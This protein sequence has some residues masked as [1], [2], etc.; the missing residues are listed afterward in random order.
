MDDH[1]F[2]FTY[3]GRESEEVRKIREKYLP[4]R[5]DNLEKLRRLDKSA[6]EK[7]T[8]WS[9]V[10]G[11][12]GTLILGGGMSMCLVWTDTLLIP[13]IAVGIVGIV[14]LSLAYP[15]YKAVT[16]KERQRIAPEILRLSD[17]LLK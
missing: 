11:I 17:E 5:E 6:T 4:K 15:V 8:I 1:S 9:L 12:L 16:E 2:E 3:S 14:M 10:L 13:G 7:G